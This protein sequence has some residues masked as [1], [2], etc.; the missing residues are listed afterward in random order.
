MKQSTKN[1]LDEA[2]AQCIEQGKS[3]E[4]IIQCLQD[5]ANVDF[6]CVMNYLKKYKFKPT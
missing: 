1:L 4:Y 6:D 3:T 5:W 2:Y